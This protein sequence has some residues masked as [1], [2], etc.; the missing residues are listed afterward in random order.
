MNVDTEL[1][2]RVSLKADMTLAEALE[3]EKTLTDFVP[4]PASAALL[5]ALAIQLLAA[6][7]AVRRSA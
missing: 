6:Q 5:H 2:V 3:L 7:R 1:E 4:T